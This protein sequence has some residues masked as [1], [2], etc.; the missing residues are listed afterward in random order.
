[1]LVENLRL[2]RQ[3]CGRTLEHETARRKHMDLISDRHGQLQVL[4]DQQDGVAALAQPP[5][6][7]LDLEHQPGRSPSDGSS[8][9]I[10]SGLAISAR[11]MASICCSP[12]LSAP[13][14]MVD[15]FGKLREFREHLVEIPTVS[16]LAFGRRAPRAAASTLVGSS[17]FSRTL[18]ERKIRRPCGTIA[19][20]SWAIA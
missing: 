15:A 19:M 20:P 6:D 3:R 2:I 1:M 8:I 4:L 11:P 9:K 18:S 17:R 7:L 5:H 14:R 12:P 10:S 13:P 16:G